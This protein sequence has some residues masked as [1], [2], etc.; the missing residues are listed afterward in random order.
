MAGQTG[1]VGFESVCGGIL[2]CYVVEQGGVDEGFEHAGCRGRMCVG[3]E[4]E[5]CGAGLLPGVD[6]LVV[7]VAILEAGVHRVARRCGHLG[8]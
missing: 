3:A 2:H 1:D 7:C 6:F 8:E 4:V 5:C